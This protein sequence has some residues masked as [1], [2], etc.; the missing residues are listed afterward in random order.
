MFNIN[1]INVTDEDIAEIEAIFGFLL[2]DGQKKLLRYWDS[3]DIQACPGSGKTTTLAAKLIILA[4]KIPNSF[5]QGICIITHTNTAVA[6]IKE[7]LGP[8][9]SFYSKYP[10]HFGTIQSF[11]DKFLAIPRYKNE[12]K[13]APNII[14]FETYSKA[15][16]KIPSLKYSGTINLFDIKNIDLGGL[17]YN[18]HNFSISKNIN[19]AERFTINGLKPETI[20]KHYDKVFNAK[21]SLF[22]D[23]YLKYDEAY[24]LS[25]K[26]IREIPKLKE[27]LPKRFPFVYIDEMQ[28]MER[29]QSEIIE[30]LF[31]SSKTVLQKIGDTNQS[32]YSYGRSESDNESEWQPKINSELQLVESNRISDNIVDL[33]RDVCI[34]PQTSMVGWKNPQPIRPAI[35]VYKS[36]SIHLVKD[37][38]ARLIIKNEISPE[39]VFKCVGARLSDAVLNINSYWPD[40]NRAKERTE[41]KNLIS[42][43]LAIKKSIIISRNLKEVR[44]L[45]W[46]SYCKC[47]RIC[48][49]KNPSTNYY[50]TAYSLQQ[51]LKSIGSEN[52]IIEF[53]TQI[54]KW[55]DD[56]RDS[57]DI[58][59]DFVIYFKSLLIFL[60]GNINQDLTDFIANKEIEELD[61]KKE[62]RKYSFS[63]NGKVIDLHFDTIHGVK[64]ETHTATLYLETFNRTYD[65]GGK[66]IEFIISNDKD[67]SRQRG[68]PAVKKKLPLAYVALTRATHF[69]AIA[70]NSERFTDNHKRY[71]EEKDTEWEIL[72]I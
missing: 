67:K 13:H 21:E 68:I 49:L 5:H 66:I 44:K 24:S 50:Y 20:K 18:K 36:E 9:A 14:D 71:F 30:I 29:H 41:F 17:S 37:T 28:D 57:K 23:G 33:V 27:I 61:E 8:Y 19:D 2:N 47:F 6:E 53:D 52:K 34:S 48:N 72:Y 54:S 56:L 42:Y 11:V 51:Y 26:Y 58:F 35:I 10:H 69:V 59:D 31:G 43:I 4:K 38:F 16:N 70:V 39:K 65:I 15:I 22:S 45:F 63:E 55:I 32:I 62:T 60:G 7:K 64:G 1:Q 46:E 3:V 12:F 25:Y 40:F